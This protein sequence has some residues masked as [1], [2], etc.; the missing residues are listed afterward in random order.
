MKK[1]FFMG[2]MGMFLL[3]SC[4]NHSGH[5]HEGHDH[6]GCT[7]SHEEQAHNHE[8]HSHEQDHEGHNH[9]AGEHNHEGHN[10]E[11]TDAHEQEGHSH[12]GHNH[13]Q[14]A[15][16]DAHAGHDHGHEHGSNPDEIILAPEKAKAAGVAS[17]EIQPKAFRQVIKASGEVQ[18]AQGNESTIVANVSGVV[19]FQRS[20]TEGMQVGKGTAL[21]SISASNLQDGDPAERARIAYE[22][23]KADFDRASRLVES[24]IVSQKE[25]N[26]IKEKYES[27]KLAY[28]ALSKNQTKNGVSVT[29]PMGGY[30]KNLLV[31]EGDYVAVGQPLATVTQNNRLFLRADVSE[32]Y[33]KY[34]NGITS[35]NFK[36]PYDNQVY[37]LEALNGKLLSYGKSAGS[38]YVPVTFSFDNKGDIMPGSFVEIYLLSKPMENTIA[39]PIEALTEEQGLYFI[40]IQKCAESY[41]KQ[42][43]KL[44]ASNGKEVEILS[45]VNPG[46][47][48]VVKGAYH[49]KL[50]SAS[51]ALPAHS[52]EH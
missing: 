16:A 33:Y 38:F 37:E 25:F 26:A 27:A 14:E 51:N 3:G 30:I 7:H 15:K 23:A 11:A 1:L 34:L 17:M 52:H 47:K 35:A 31:K 18:S 36:T 46:D 48:V 19:S 40:Y 13:A 21:M 28:E 8:G 22:S 10:H 44:G 41:R 24:Q 9:E 29:S 39:L 50:A 2:V 5:S 12:E 43:V 20:V 4:N 45:G 49:V 42:E 32:R 6:E